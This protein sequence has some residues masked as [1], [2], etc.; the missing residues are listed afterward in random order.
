MVA[1]LRCSAASFVDVVVPLVMEE[2]AEAV[3]LISQVRIRQRALQEILGVPLP[4]IQEQS[5]EVD[6]EGVQTMTMTTRLAQ[7]EHS[8]ALPQVTSCL[9]TAKEFGANAGQD[10]FPSVRDGETVGGSAEDCFPGQNPAADCGA[11]R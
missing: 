5:V 11:D 9:S 6:F 2:I 4:L 1:E 7:K 3:K 10:P 8:A